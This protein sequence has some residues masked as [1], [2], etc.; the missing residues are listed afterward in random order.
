MGGRVGRRKR[1]KGSPN[2]IKSE[3]CE[4][5]RETDAEGRGQR[6]SERFL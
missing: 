4:E 2:E 6:K 1:L 3:S 5:E